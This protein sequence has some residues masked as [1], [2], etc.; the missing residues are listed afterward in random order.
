MP[1]S[2]PGIGSAGFFENFGSAGTLNYG[3]ASSDIEEG[4]A[5]F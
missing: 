4:F 2:L 3:K 5:I 1:E